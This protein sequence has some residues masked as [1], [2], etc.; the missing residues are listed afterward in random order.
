MGA[1]ASSNYAIEDIR[2]ASLENLTTACADLPSKERQRLTE[3]IK[4]Y[5][6]PNDTNTDAQID[7]KNE[8]ESLTDGCRK[9]G[10]QR[11]HRGLSRRDEQPETGL[12]QDPSETNCLVCKPP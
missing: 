2:D 5:E 7:E 12:L 3:M 4:M 1:G 10:A 8:G 11:R 6:L 9:K